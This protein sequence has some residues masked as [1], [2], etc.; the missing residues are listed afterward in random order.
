MYRYRARSASENRPSIFP[1]RGSGGCW[2][3][4]NVWKHK[5]LIITE[6]IDP[7][8]VGNWH[9]KSTQPYHTLS[10]VEKRPPASPCHQNFVVM[11]TS[12]T[13]TTAA[14]SSLNAETANI[15]NVP[16]HPQQDHAAMMPLS[17]EQALIALNNTAIELMQ[18]GL[19]QSALKAFQDALQ[20]MK[21]TADAAS[22]RTAQQHAAQCQKIAAP[23]ASPLTPTAA[24]AEFVVVSSLTDVSVVYHLLAEKRTSKVFL[25]LDQVHPSGVNKDDPVAT[26]SFLAMVRSIVVYNY[27]IAHR[28][29]SYSSAEHHQPNV[30]SFCVQVFQYAESLLPGSFSVNSTDNTNTDDNSNLMF[31]LLLTRNLMMLSCRLGMSMCEHY[32]ET[33][34]PIVDRI[35]SSTLS[36]SNNEDDELMVNRHHELQDKAPAA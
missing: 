5:T 10:Q 33:L 29:F 13:S 24:E 17:L 34:D 2:T 12:T 36:N 28:C 7:S 23:A 18:R 11:K 9:G 30:G 1:N 14:D 21:P 26:S 8:T 6:L 27:G 35:L 31:R 22:I 32:K 15:I 16:L 3:R 25:R 20:V 4:E 19:Q